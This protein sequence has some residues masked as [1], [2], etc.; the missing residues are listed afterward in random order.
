[1][2]KRYNFLVQE[3]ADL[4]REAR[5]LLAAA[6]GRDLT[7]EER[8]RD[9]QINARLE[10]LAGEIEREERLRLYDRQVAPLA[11]PAYNKLPRGDTHA[12]AFRHWALTGD[13]GGLEAG[14]FNQID[15]VGE[16]YTIQAASNA[17][18]M[19]IGTAADGGDT[20]PT[21]FYNR[22]IARRDEMSLAAKLPLLNIPVGPGNSF[23][24]PVDNEADGEFVATTEADTFDLDS[25][26][27][28]KK[29]GALV[30]YS[31]YTDVSHQLLR[32]SAA[33][34]EGFL[35]DWVGRGYAKTLN[36]LLLTEVAANGTAFKTFASATAIA[37]GEPEDIVG[38][39]D[40]ADYM[41]DEAAIAWVMRSAT[42][43]DIKSLTGNDRQYAVNVDSGKTLLGYPVHYSQKAAATAA[44]A[45]DVYFGNWQY[46]AHAE[47]NK[48]TFMRDPYT[49]AV[50][51][52]VRLLWFFE[53]DFVV[54]QAE[55][56]G[57]GV[58]PSA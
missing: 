34:V 38:N 20:V 5:A 46:V 54:T 6:D 40:L 10:T 23:E 56:I 8:G 18:D 35:V 2:S 28:A 15:G 43:W 1:M 36:S 21:A 39:N 37:F 52:Q 45:K 27:V 55:A 32:A 51:G 7:D 25:P 49:V 17:T 16:G 29:Q 12:E 19:N 22:I 31:K 57:Y 47:G 30:L 50:K 48:L 9:D 42:H 33:D 24:I 41:D 4:V 53:A 58:H 26:A 3:R 44:S 11:A 14:Q 13:R